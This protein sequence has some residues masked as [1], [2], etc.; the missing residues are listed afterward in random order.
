MRGHPHRLVHH[1]EVVVVVHDLEP[2]R[3]RCD[4]GDGRG[5]TRQCDL[6]TASLHD[7]LGLRRR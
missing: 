6:E 2:G 4:H 5:P 1:H 3:G 7:P